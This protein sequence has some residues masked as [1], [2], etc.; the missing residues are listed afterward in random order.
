MEGAG[1]PEVAGTNDRTRGRRIGV[2]R[3]GRD[4]NPVVESGK[5]CLQ[6]QS[7]CFE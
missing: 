3:D 5:K 7:D 6:G 2:G 4:T 1:W